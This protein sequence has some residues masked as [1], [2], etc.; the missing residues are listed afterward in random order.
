MGN[1]SLYPNKKID[2]KFKA[3]NEVIFSNQL[4]KIL[5]LLSIA[6]DEVHLALIRIYWS[7]R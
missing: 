6:S 7:G 1:N 4:N 3:I 2:T 5:N